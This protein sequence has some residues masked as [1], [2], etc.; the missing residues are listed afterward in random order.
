MLG[1]GATGTVINIRAKL[2]GSGVNKTFTVMTGA[3]LPIEAGRLYGLSTDTVVIATVTKEVE[4]VVNFA[5]TGAVQTFT[6][7]VDGVYTLEAWGGAGRVGHRFATNSTA[8]AGGLGGYSLSTRTMT[9]G[10]RLY[11]YVGQEGFSVD[12][13]AWNGG[14]TYTTQSWGAGGGGGATDFRTVGGSW[15]DAGS[16]ASR[17]LVAGGGGGGGSTNPVWVTEATGG[18][19][20][21]AGGGGTSAGGAGRDGTG[22]DYIGKGGGG[23]SNQGG[24]P[25]GG[26]AGSGTY[27]SGNTNGLSGGVGKGADTPVSTYSSNVGDGGAGGGG[28]GGGGSGGA[29]FG[30]SSR[31][32]GGGGGGGGGSYGASAGAPGVNSGA[33][34]ARVTYR[35]SIQVRP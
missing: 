13:A 31:G 4:V 14:G 2:K 3:N 6:A 8:G 5:S 20:G 22:K 24:S 16:L 34:K 28:Y 33:G 18:G 35:T 25:K 9:A 1:A 12:R 26:A 27:Y 11:I 10:E 7:P 19:D 29:G 17:I 23:G 21:G 30:A 15:D 32:G